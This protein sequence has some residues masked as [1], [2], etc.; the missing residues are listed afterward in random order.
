MKD[1]TFPIINQATLFSVAFVLLVILGTFLFQYGYR[2][3]GFVLIGISLVCLLATFIYFT[4]QAQRLQFTVQGIM[5]YS[6][7]RCRTYFWSQ[8]KDVKIKENEQ[9]K[10]LIVE[11]YQSGSNQTRPDNYFEV[12]INAKIYGYNPEELKDIIRKYLSQQG[13]QH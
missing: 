4:P 12:P 10:Q 3:F 1:R 8:M 2:Q 13:A 6:Y 11:L 9:E 5:F 7:G